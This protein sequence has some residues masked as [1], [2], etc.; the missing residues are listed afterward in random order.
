MGRSRAAPHRDYTAGRRAR[1][2]WSIA[3]GASARHRERISTRC[4]FPRDAALCCG[5]CAGPRHYLRVAMAPRSPGR[6]RQSP[7]AAA[8]SPLRPA[9]APQPRLSAGQRSAGPPRAPP[10]PR[11]RPAIGRAAGGAGPGPARRPRGA[12]SRG[13]LLTGPAPRFGSARY[14]TVPPARHPRAPRPPSLVRA[15]SARLPHSSC[16]CRPLCELW[17]PAW[18]TV[19]IGQGKPK[20][21]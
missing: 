15:E 20:K 3:P 5:S 4:P 8:P 14:R 17:R 2:R 6:P 18:E 10:R 16:C 19:T 7:L 1:L 13:A 21:V 12:R 9:P 11:A